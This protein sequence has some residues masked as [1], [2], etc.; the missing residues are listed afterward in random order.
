MS[1]T[2]G[3][4]SG[5]RITPASAEQTQLAIKHLTTALRS[6]DTLDNS[7]L[8]ADVVV[9]GPRLW[10][11]LRDR[12]QTVPE[13]GAFLVAVISD[14]A[15]A[16]KWGMQRLDIASLPEDKRAVYAAIQKE[17]YLVEEGVMKQGAPNLMKALGEMF[18][19]GT[20]LL[21][22]PAASAEISYYWSLISYDL[23]AP[24]LTLES[25]SGNFLFDFDVEQRVSF[26]ELLP[27]KL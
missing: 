17:G 18:T 8:A 2:I 27:E 3:V 16:R 14:D 7:G 13:R 22:R 15:A 12:L 11:K 6:L 24:I 19:P 21:I 26:I 25:S 1:A 9:V 20:K 23:D 10:S 5:I 4:A